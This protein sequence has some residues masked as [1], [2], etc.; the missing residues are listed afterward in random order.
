MLIVTLPMVIVTSSA[1]LDRLGD[2][3]AGSLRGGCYA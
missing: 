3:E 2:P 1:R